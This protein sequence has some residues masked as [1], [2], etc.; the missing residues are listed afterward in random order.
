MITIVFEPDNKRAAAYDQDKLVGECTY[1]PSDTL[2]IIDHTEVDPSYGGQG[3]AANLVKAVAD[4]ARAA[5][6]KVLPLCPYAKR[7]FERKPEYQDLL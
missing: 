6:V 2:W 4:A 3:I 7:E 1:S 5:K